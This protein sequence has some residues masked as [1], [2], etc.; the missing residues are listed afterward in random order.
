MLRIRKF[1]VTLKNAR[2]CS[3]RGSTAR[4][5]QG[6]I[7]LP[8]ESWCK[9]VETVVHFHV[10]STDQLAPSEFYHSLFSCTTI[11]PRY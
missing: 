1:M 6:A 10:L 8:E 5:E 4:S 9:V 2:T 11:N 3:C 7:P